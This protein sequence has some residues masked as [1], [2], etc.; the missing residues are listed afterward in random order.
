MKC[1]HA[2]NLTQA[3]LQRYM[4]VLRKQARERKEILLNCEIIKSEYRD[5]YENNEKKKRIVVF[6]RGSGCSRV[7][8]VGGCTFC[9][10]YNAT[11]K[12][13]KIKDE[14]YILQI[15]SIIDKWDSD[16][17]KICL[18]NDGSLLCDKEMSFLTLIEI[19]KLIDGDENITSITIE[20]KIEDISEIK[21]QEIRKIT[22]KNLE[23]AV[24]FES[25]NFVVR[26][27]CINKS[28]ENAVFEK[29]CKIA[30]K[31]TVDIIPLTMLKPPFLTE[32]EAAEDFINSL[33]YLEKFHLRRVDIELPTVE[34]DTLSFELWESGRYKPASLWTLVYILH[35][36]ER[37][38]LNTP[39]YVS[40]MEYSVDAYDK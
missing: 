8:S 40:P 27:L 28:F 12:G 26:D 9:G 33:R 13:E 36:K 6:L 14:D 30:Q 37:L 16:T 10:F 11:N 19:L 32:K 23:I 39:L 17:T 7:E 20:S 31:Y 25:A 24:G 5:Y 21:L 38:K 35:E 22:K 34:I 2:L 15:K 1:V 29:V 18:Y 4:K 3:R